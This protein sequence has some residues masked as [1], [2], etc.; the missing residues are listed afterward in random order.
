[1]IDELRYVQGYFLV[2]KGT[3]GTALAMGNKRKQKEAKDRPMDGKGERIA[4]AMGKTVE[5]KGKIGA[6]G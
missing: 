1:M 4:R 2:L 6:K 5:T 3:T